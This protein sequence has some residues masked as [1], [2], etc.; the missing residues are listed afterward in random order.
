MLDY[1]FTK[2][3][4][5]GYG[6]K[7]KGDKIAKLIKKEPHKENIV[8]KPTDEAGNLIDETGGGSTGGGSTGGGSTGGGTGTGTN[9]EYEMF[10]SP[11][12]NTIMIDGVDQTAFFPEG[13]IYPVELTPDNIDPNN[14]TTL[15]IT[16]PYPWEITVYADTTILNVGSMNS[17]NLP[18]LWAPDVQGGGK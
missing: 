12:S 17:S 13:F 2:M 11:F 15:Y 7:T 6:N 5:P 3:T 4:T 14:L 10:F 16:D 9:T 1:S 18:F 8:S